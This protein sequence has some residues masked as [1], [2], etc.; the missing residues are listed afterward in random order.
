MSC[1]TY[2][3]CRPEVPHPCFI[4]SAWEKNEQLETQWTSLKVKFMNEDIV[5]AQWVFSFHFG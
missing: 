5:V 4:I 3:A 2:T 1:L